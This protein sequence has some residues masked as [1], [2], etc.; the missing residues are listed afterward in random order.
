V[1]AIPDEGFTGA[2]LLLDV[3]KTVDDQKK[4]DDLYE[5]V[6]RQP[7]DPL[8]ILIKASDCKFGDEWYYY[9]QYFFANEGTRLS[10]LGS[11]KEC[12]G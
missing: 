11:S 1:L 6:V 2:F 3:Q 8:K 10:R 7:D 9:L 5:T 4:I 12:F